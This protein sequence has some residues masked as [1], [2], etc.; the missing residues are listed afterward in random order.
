MNSQPPKNTNKTIVSTPKTSDPRSITQLDKHTTTGN[1]N[2]SSTTEERT[3]TIILGDSH[4]R[5]LAVKMKNTT[6]LVN[7][8]RPAEYFDTSIVKNYDKVILLAGSNNIPSKD[9]PE[10]INQKISNTIASIKSVNPTCKLFVQSVLPRHDI[11]RSFKISQVN[12]LL[13]T[14]CDLHDATLMQTPVLQ[15]HN[16]TRHGLHLNNTGKI[17]LARSLSSYVEEDT[18][19]SPAASSDS[20]FLC[21]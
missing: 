4:A 2:K 1:N 9:T 20:P 15:R 6:A 19:A 13:K 14:T 5:H 16:F 8:G 7:P 21:T 10:E 18:S 12:T 11:I 17:K 3:T